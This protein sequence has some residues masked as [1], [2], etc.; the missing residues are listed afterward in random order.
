MDMMKQSGRTRRLLA[1]HC[2]TYPQLSIQDV[3]KFLYQSSFGCE[4]L[5]ASPEK[6]TEYISGEYAAVS[7]EDEHTVEAL[8]GDYSRVHLAYMKQGLGAGTLGRIFVLSAKHEENGM[9]EL[10]QKIKTTKEM[11]REGSLPFTLNEFEEAVS[12]W[13]AKG[14]PAIRHSEVFRETYRPAY[15]VIANRYIPFL[16]MLAEIDRRLAKGSVLLSIEGGS[17]SGKTTLSKILEEIYICTVFHMDD[18]FLQPEQRTPERFA[19]VGGNIDRERFLSE[20]LLPL[21]KGENVRFRKFDCSTMSL[22]EEE[23]LWP[24]KLVIAEGAYSMHPELAQYYDF[25]VFLDISPQLQQERILHRNSPKMAQ[26]FFR[27]WIPLENAY[28]EK[29]DVKNR[30][31]MVISIDNDE[32]VYLPERKGL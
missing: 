31:S 3:L 26:R 32:P 17:A 6:V 10:L 15:R 30:C 5:I 23:E 7:P 11:I 21:S 9:S 2:Q 19:E 8:D 29:T 13:E 24:E 12:Q 18:F 20:V 27:E 1:M 14:Y 22:G 25:S 4:H 28:F 16:P